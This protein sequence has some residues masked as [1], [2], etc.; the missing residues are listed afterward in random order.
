MKCPQCGYENREGAKFCKKCGQPLK[1]ELICP[2]CRYANTP[3]SDFC[4]QCG[5]RLADTSSSL[6]PPIPP[7]QPTQ[8]QPISFAS[9][10]YQVKQLLGEGNDKKV[11]L[12]HDTQM[13]RDVAFSLLKVEKPEAVTRGRITREAVAFALLKTDRLEALKQPQ[14]ANQYMH[15][16]QHPHR[17]L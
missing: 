11:F 9:G 3:D 7:T 17:E 1:T 6:Q 16:N 4:E 2:K 13:D 15:R 5:Y 12:A 8:E 14:T 10:R